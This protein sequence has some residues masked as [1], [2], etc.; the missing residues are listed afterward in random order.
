M[1]KNQKLNQI[2]IKK[3]GYPSVFDLYEEEDKTEQMS[4]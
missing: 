3:I 1:G 4:Q 2:Q